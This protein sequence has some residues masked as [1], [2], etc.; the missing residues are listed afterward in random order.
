MWG[1]FV[2]HPSVWSDNFRASSGCPTQMLVNLMEMVVETCSILRT[3]LPRGD[4]APARP[5]EASLPSL[6]HPASILPQPWGP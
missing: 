6:R 2:S 4:L 5:Q 3:G 1:S